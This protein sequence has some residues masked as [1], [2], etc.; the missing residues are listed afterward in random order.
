MHCVALN[1]P[2]G[3]KI[4]AEKRNRTTTLRHALNRPGILL[5]PGCHDALS[6]K[7]IE[8][9]QFPYTFMSGFTTSAS[10]LAA[11][12]VGLITYSEMVQTGRAIH[13]ATNRIP[14]IGDGDTGYGNPLNVKRTVQGYSSA[15]FAGILIED[16]VWPKSCGHVRG[17]QVVSREEAVARVVAAVEARDSGDDIMILARTDARQAQSLNEALYRIQAFADAGADILFIDALTD[18]Q[19]ME[20]FC[21][22]APFVPKLANM[23]E[24]GGKTPILSPR[25]LENV[26]YKLVAYP[27]SLLGVSMKAMDRALDYLKLGQ[28]P[29]LDFEEMK[30]T[31]GFE[32][33]FDE[34]DGYQKKAVEILQKLD[35]R[36]V[37]P[38]VKLPIEAKGSDTPQD[39]NGNSAPGTLEADAVFPPDSSSKSVV[40]MEQE[41]ESQ[42]QDQQKMATFARIVV[43]NVKTEEI[44]LETR[45]P[46]GF[47]RDISKFVPEMEGFDLRGLLDKTETVSNS[48]VFT[49]TEKK[50]R[51]EIYLE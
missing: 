1:R 20:A 5:G 15:G 29:E 28:V 27:L 48:P 17:K 14:V 3:L 10:K 37:A 34:R 24:G 19:E 47:I 31:L 45:I 21:N 2:Y 7:L 6:A 25:E 33:Y 11:P 36:P 50:N 40:V 22:L 44:K 51:T 43:T 18:V 16:Q 26:G 4:R 23:L 13:E 38:D 41:S 39:R 30:D 8:N 42:Q 46:I 12:D 49:F 32:K 35:R 9:A